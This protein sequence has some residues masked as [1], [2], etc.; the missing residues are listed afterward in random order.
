MLG[1]ELP[2]FHDLAQSWPRYVAFP[3]AWVSGWIVSGTAVPAD[4]RLVVAAVLVIAS[5]ALL[6][7]AAAALGIE[8]TG[9]RCRARTN[10]GTRCQHPRPPGADCCRAVHQRMHG[11]ELV[12]G[13]GRV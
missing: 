9:G 11:V 1:P 13:D 12:D 3:A 4:Y 2:T 8:L 6:Y 5:T 10:D 7:G